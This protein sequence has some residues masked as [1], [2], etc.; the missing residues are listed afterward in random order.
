MKLKAARILMVIVNIQLKTILGTI[1]ILVSRCGDMGVQVE[2][3]TVFD[4][5]DCGFFGNQCNNDD[6]GALGRHWKI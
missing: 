5:K 3:S 1:F 6:Y 4:K 2:D